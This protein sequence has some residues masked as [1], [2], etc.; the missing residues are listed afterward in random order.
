MQERLELFHQ[1]TFSKAFT[2]L[3]DKLQLVYQTH[4]WTGLFAIS[5]DRRDIIIPTHILSIIKKYDDVLM[6]NTFVMKVPHLLIGPS[7]NQQLY[8]TKILILIKYQS[9]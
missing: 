7:S 1:C 8:S 4:P 2:V 6:Y 5:L 9:P 3:I